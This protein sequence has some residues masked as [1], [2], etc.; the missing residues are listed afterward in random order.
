MKARTLLTIIVTLVACSVTCNVAASGQNVQ[1]FPFPYHRHIGWPFLGGALPPM[2]SNPIP[3]QPDPKV[4]K[5]LSHGGEI[6]ACVGEIVSSFFARKAAIGPLCCKAVM[7]VDEDCENAVFGSFHNPFF[8]A[9]IK[10]HCASQA[11]PTPA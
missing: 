4:T 1:W 7:M 10:Q 3:F 2:P 6:G 9:Y 11:S 5:C 8:N